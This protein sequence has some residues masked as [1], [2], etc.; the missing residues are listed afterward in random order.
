MYLGPNTDTYIPNYAPDFVARDRRDSY[1]R[2]DGRSRERDDRY[3]DRERGTRTRSRSPGL[4]GAAAGG[5]GG[6]ERERE[7]VSRDREV[8]RR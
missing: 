6:R 2:G 3:G 4:R 1:D 7:G 8:Y 5:G